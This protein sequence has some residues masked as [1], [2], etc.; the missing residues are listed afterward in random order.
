M[1]LWIEFIVFNTSTSKYMYKTINTTDYDASPIIALIIF[2][3]TIYYYLH[4]INL[5][6]SLL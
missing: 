6:Q 1:A 3:T 4:P 2:H 5:A